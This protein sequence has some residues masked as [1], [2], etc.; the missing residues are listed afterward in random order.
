MLFELLVADAGVAFAMSMPTAG[1]VIAIVTA[2][3]LLALSGFISAS[4]TAFF[5]L[6][7]EELAQVDSQDTPHSKAVSAL[8]ADRERLLATILTVNNLVNVAIVLLLDLAFA[9]MISFGAEWLEFLVIT[10]LLTFILLLF[11]EIV[12][13]LYSSHNS[14]PFSLKAAPVLTV[15]ETVFKP[16]SSLLMRSSALAGHG[17]QSNGYSIS[18]DQ[19]EHALELTDSDDI[20]EEHQILEGVIRFGD[21]KVVDIMTSRVDMVMLDV[22][23]TYGDVMSC[24]GENFYSRVPV[25]SG[26]SDNIRGILYIK[27]LLPYLEKGDGFRWQSL[28]RPAFFV[29]ETRRLDDLLHDF[30]TGR[31]HMAI[32]VDEY[33]GTSGLVTLEDV[34]EEILGEINDEFDEDPVRYR[35]TGPDTYIFDGKMLLQDFFRVLDVDADDFAGLVGEADT[36]AGLLLELKGD[37]PRKD[38]EFQCRNLTL[39]VIEKK[40]H[41]ISGVKVTVTR[42]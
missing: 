35:K 13:K 7:P 29:P 28:I 19:L 10:V 25:Y 42:A 15:L 24:I 8:I 9:Q 41:R 12:P 6:T 34:I 20:Q 3:L 4:E 5:S 36:I 33:G 21:E 11:G 14:L 38:E 18:V 37:F 39:R 22:K 17:R 23:A 26:T 30:Q 16:V 2:L 40:E 1:S 32:V 27:D 31:I